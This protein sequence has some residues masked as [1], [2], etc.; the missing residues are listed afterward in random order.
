LP[1]L[2]GRT[3][4][5]ILS[6]HHHAC[7]L[8][9]DD[10]TLVALVSEVHGNGPF[11]IVVPGARF[12]TITTVSP[13]VWHAS[14]LHIGPY[15]IALRE[16]RPWHPRVAKITI[17]EPTDFLLAHLSSLQSAS[18]LYTGLPALVER[19]QHGMD[20]LQSGLIPHNEQ[21]IDEGTKQLAGLGPGL[22]PAGDDFLVG[23][24][25]ALTV[26]PARWSA[27]AAIRQQ[28]A[29]CAQS[30][31]T[32]LSGAWLTHAGVGHFGEGWHQLVAAFNGGVATSIIDSVTAMAMTGATSGIDALCGFHFGLQLVAR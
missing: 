20:Q 5:S 28:I 19:A 32:R 31:T 24:L 29:T 16:A 23:L 15:T 6:H 22:T 14:L 7:N 4:W 9:T 1:H 8:L 21:F 12:D 3:A 25:A 17:F 2:A 11:H 13:V 26:W 30:R 10:G 27:T 18:P